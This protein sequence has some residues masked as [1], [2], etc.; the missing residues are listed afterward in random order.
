MDEPSD[1]TGRANKIADRTK[2]IYIYIEG[3]EKNKNNMEQ[4]QII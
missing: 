2:L 3:Q 4:Q 1:N